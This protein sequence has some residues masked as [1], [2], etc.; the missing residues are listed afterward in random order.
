MQITFGGFRKKMEVQSLKRS[1]QI[2]VIRFIF[3]L[4]TEELSHNMFKRNTFDLCSWINPCP[5]ET[6][7]S[8][9]RVYI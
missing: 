1:R 3:K 2:N 6:G 8:G 5:G 7:D 9:G 4:E